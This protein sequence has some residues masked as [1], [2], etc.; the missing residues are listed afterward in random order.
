MNP[1]T[2]IKIITVVG[3]LLT[4]VGEILKDLNESHKLGSTMNGTKE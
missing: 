2:I 4:G 3:A 1:G